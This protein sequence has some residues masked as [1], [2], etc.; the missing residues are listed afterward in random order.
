[1]LLNEFGTACFVRNSFV[2]RYVS[3]DTEGHIIVFNTGSLT[4]FIQNPG[5]TQKA[6]DLGK[7]CFQLL[8]RT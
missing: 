5:L 1:M 7:I 8:S 6:V 2:I 3:F 4:I